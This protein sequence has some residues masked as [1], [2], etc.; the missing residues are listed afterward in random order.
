MFRFSNEGAVGSVRF[1]LHSYM[2][3]L[4]SKRIIFV[5]FLLSH[6][7][8][9]CIFQECRRLKEGIL[10]WYYIRNTKPMARATTAKIES[11]VLGISVY[12]R[13]HHIFILRNVTENQEQQRNVH[14][15]PVKYRLTWYTVWPLV[16]L[17]W[18]YLAN[19]L[20]LFSWH[21]FA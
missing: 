8:K 6:R 21:I 4:F 16:A 3:L 5:F 14:P 1:W 9:F 20:L 11:K 12:F 17:S 15:S 10:G 18:Q 19:R 7:N 13:Q 2:F